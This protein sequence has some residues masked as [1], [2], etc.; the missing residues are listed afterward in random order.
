M[1]R[2]HE[3]N[4][5]FRHSI[6]SNPNDSRVNTIVP[7]KITEAGALAILPKTKKNFKAFKA[8]YL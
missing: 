5:D 6:E 2:G 4:P 7:A 1:F 3:K 8:N